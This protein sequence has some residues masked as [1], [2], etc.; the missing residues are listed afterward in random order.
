MNNLQQGSRS[1]MVRH[2]AAR[3]PDSPTV[4]R[5]LAMIP[6]NLRRNT[7]SAAP[8]MLTSADREAAPALLPEIVQETRR[9][10]EHQARENRTQRREANRQRFRDLLNTPTNQAAPDFKAPTSAQEAREAVSGRVWVRQ[11]QPKPQ[12]P[13]WDALD[14]EAVLEAAPKVSKGAA[15]LFRLL[16]SVAATVGQE[17]GYRVIP[18][19]VSF[20]LPQSLVAAVAGYTPR[21]TRR[22]GAELEGAG[23]IDAGAHAASVTTENEKQRRMWDGSLWAVKL[24]PSNSDAYLTPEDWRQV[25]RDFDADLKHGRTAQKLMSHLKTYEDVE[26][27]EHV[28]QLWA[29]NPNAN[30][31]PLSLERTWEARKRE[32]VQ[33]VVYSLPLLADLSGHQLTEAIGRAASEIAHALNDQHSRRYWCALLWAAV[34]NKTL[35]SFSAQLLRLLTDVQEWPEMQNPGAVFTARLRTA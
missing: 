5:F 11:A 4:D 3:F 30:L 12:G 15:H 28:L 2:E 19:T 18:S 7:P 17:R 29:V 21:H 9:R 8:L 23:L 22:L 27:K 1:A 24:K 14:A 6:A 32:S 16:H 34:K 35:S 33:D 31:S 10:L 26:R 20:H 25:W 13:D